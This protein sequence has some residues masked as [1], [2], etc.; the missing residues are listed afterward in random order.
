VRQKDDPTKC[1]LRRYDLRQQPISQSKVDVHLEDINFAVGQQPKFVL[2][3]AKKVTWKE[4]Q[5]EYV[6]E[7][8]AKS[9]DLR[10]TFDGERV[11]VAYQSVDL[12][13]VR[14]VSI[15]YNQ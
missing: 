8:L 1:Y 7:E 13:A 9:E 2:C 5:S 10:E 6:D 4:G 14:V 12:K 11:L 15:D 3:Y